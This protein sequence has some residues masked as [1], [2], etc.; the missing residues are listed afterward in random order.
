MYGTYYIYIYQLSMAHVGN[1]WE[2]K[3]IVLA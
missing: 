1:I 3:T 2:I